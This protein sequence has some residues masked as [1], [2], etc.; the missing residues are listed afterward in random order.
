MPYSVIARHRIGTQGTLILY[1]CGHQLDR[2]RH[3]TCFDNYSTEKT[4]IVL[5]FTGANNDATIA[6]GSTWMGAAREGDAAERENERRRREPDFVPRTVHGAGAHFVIERAGEDGEAKVVQA[7]TDLS[8]APKHCVASINAVSFGI[9]I[10]NPGGP[11][12]PRRPLPADGDYDRL[13]LRINNN[14]TPSLHGSGSYGNCTPGRYASYQDE[15]Y[16]SIILL[17]RYLCDRY[18]LKK[19]FLGD[20]ASRGNYAYHKL[21]NYYREHLRG[22]ARNSMHAHS[23]VN[24]YEGILSHCNFQSGDK[25]CG[26]PALHRNRIFRGIIDE[27][28]M[29][30]DL[31]SFPRG[32][33]TGPY[34]PRHR[35]LQKWNEDGEPVNRSFGF[36]SSASDDDDECYDHHESLQETRSYYHLASHPA[37]LAHTLNVPGSY[38]TGLNGR[39]HYGVHLVP[40]DNSGEGIDRVYA[41][42]T[43]RIVAADVTTA[44]VS[45]VGSPRFVL[46]EHPPLGENREALYSLYMHL[47]Q[48]GGGRESWPHWL[49]EHGSRP[50]G[51]FHPDVT[52]MVGDHL[53][54]AGRWYEF[55]HCLHFE[56]FEKPSPSAEATGTT[57][58][59]GEENSEPVCPPACR[60]YENVNVN[61]PGDG[62]LKFYHPINFMLRR[63]GIQVQGDHFSGG[64]LAEVS[65]EVAESLVNSFRVGEFD[66]CLDGEAGSNSRGCEFKFSY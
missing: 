51:V 23:R 33:Y 61:L 19:R 52:V 26:G 57:E 45:G 13:H 66:I 1:N 60:W 62:R 9:E 48:V 16:Q 53:G 59:R 11:D 64:D 34:D 50:G 54:S 43:G 63:N 58:W 5:H 25:A 6:I 8:T 30:V 15:Q 56:I 65:S 7:V 2:R 29:P 42:A 32:Y 17:V 39:P 49:A 4:Q 55:P 38:P 35:Q 46:I 36:G 10:A 18:G 3:P 31:N 28:W 44:D 47:A 14:V 40:V 22:G 20:D 41:A 12:G 24:R 21:A 37:Y 27:W